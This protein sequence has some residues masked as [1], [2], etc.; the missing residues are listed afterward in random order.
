MSPGFVTGF[1]VLPFLKIR[2]TKDSVT[3]VPGFLILGA[4][5]AEGRES[6]SQGLCLLFWGAASGW[7]QWLFLPIKVNHSHL[8]ELSWYTKEEGKTKFDL[9]SPS[10][11]AKDIDD[12]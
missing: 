2:V 12:V 5:S 8:S 3:N 7:I 9:S 6:Q 4:Q 1:C 11:G 10:K